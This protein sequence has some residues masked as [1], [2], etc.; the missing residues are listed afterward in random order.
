MLSAEN[1]FYVLMWSEIEKWTSTASLLRFPNLP[2]GWELKRVGDLLNQVTK[3]HKVEGDVYYR[4]SGVRGKGEGVFHRETVK[5]K[6]LSAS[7]LQPLVP[8][9]LIYNRLFAWKES[10]A[11]VPKELANHFVSNEFPQFAV[12]KRKAIP[13]YLY[14]VFIGRKVIRAVNAAS[15]G[16]SA[17]SRNRFKEE[18]FLNF[19]I[20]LPLVPTQQK[21]VHYW[22][23]AQDNISEANKHFYQL[24]HKL[25]SSLIQ[26][27]SAYKRLKNS[28]MFVTSYSKAHQWDLKAG[29]AAAFRTSN[30]G[31][32][33]LGEFTEE[34][35]ELVRPWEEP[36]KEWPIY[37]VNNKDGVFL[38][39]YQKGKDF[40]A[41]YKRIEKNWFFH[42]PT[43]ANVGSLGIVPEVSEDAITSPEYQVWRLHSG[44]LPDFMDLIIRTNYFLTLVDFN[45]VGGVK[46]RM[47]YTNLAE[48]RLPMIDFE[49]QKK[50]AD[51]RGAILSSITKAN[52][53]VKKRKSEI[54]EMIL[55]LRPVEGA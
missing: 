4:L 3:K 43:R 17:V 23:S 53:T 35:T 1:R 48:I 16:S 42:N 44:F 36:E 30:P 51:Q 22:K 28:R 32:I 37:G 14:L 10:F 5:G 45:R 11:V 54:E 12:N 39:S 2:K 40:N 6:D 34:C 46:Q 20:P 31:F 9:A 21:I 33:R 52:K 55:G 27:T 29:R 26:N 25:S 7:W 38:S 18:D 19:T 24:I 41:P 15:I 47:Y 8:G 13:E 50:F 49:T